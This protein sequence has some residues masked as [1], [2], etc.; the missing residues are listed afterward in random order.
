MGM[1]RGVAAVA[2]AL[3]AGGCMPAAYEAPALACTEHIG[4]PISS[5]IA[6]LGPPRRVYRIDATRVGYVFESREVRYV[7]GEPYYTVNYLTHVDKKR[8]PVRPVTT[9]CTG[10]F[11]THAPTDAMPAS[12]RIVV[13]I[14]P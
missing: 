2:G 4:K 8:A 13:D 11:I 6:A 14:V 3:V 7:G 10:L 1:K 12:E 9:T 5:R